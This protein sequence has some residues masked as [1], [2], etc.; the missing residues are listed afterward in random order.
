MQYVVVIEP[1]APEN[2]DFGV[3]IPDLPGC[4]AQGA[5]L[6]EALTDAEASPN[7]GSKSGSGTSETPRRPRPR[8]TSGRNIPNGPIGSGP[9]S[10]WTCRT[11]VV[12]RTAHVQRNKRRFGFFEKTKA[13][14]RKTSERSLL[15]NGSK[16]LPKRNLGFFL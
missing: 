15:A 4:F 3:L 2:P 11:S 12:D 1:A 9:A 5:T 13:N 16:I 7:F 14:S 10:R 6:E 8:K